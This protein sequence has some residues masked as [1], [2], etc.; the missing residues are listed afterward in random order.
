MLGLDEDALATT[1]AIAT[2]LA[3]GLNAAPAQGTSRPGMT[4]M[5]V[6]EPNAARQAVLA[7]TL[8]ATGD[9]TGSE[10]CIEGPAGFLATYAGSVGGRLSHVFTGPRTV[11]VGSI[12][13]ALGTRYRLLDIMFRIYDCAGFNLP[14]IDL[15][16]AMRTEHRLEGVDI[17]NVTVLMNYIETLYPSPEFPRHADPSV[18][19]VGS[20]HYYASHAAINGGYPVVGG[21]PYGPTGNDPTKDQQV[22]DFMSRVQL[23]GV[24]DQP[25]FS[26]VVFIQTKGG[27]I[28]RDELP[29]E[30]L[31]WGLD[32]LAE[33]LREC[34]PGV[35]GGEQRIAE[36]VDLVRGVENLSTLGSLFE[37]V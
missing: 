31:T 12:T 20:T 36:I 23:L 9:V 4:E 29:Y 30:Q 11:D 8:A 13:A 26:P 2:S 34:A 7:A 24:H 35:S 33:R 17:E 1:I 27:D 3:S 5:A 21:S 22:L 6:H 10:H 16:R 18:A 25:M 28:F 32:E 19:R 15:I 14:V 37:V